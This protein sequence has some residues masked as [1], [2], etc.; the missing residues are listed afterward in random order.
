[1]KELNNAALL[2]IL[3]A[4]LL[5]WRRLPVKHPSQIPQRT[6][7]IATIEELCRR[8]EE[9]DSKF[10]GL[11]SQIQAQT[12]EVSRLKALVNNLEILN[13][14]LGSNLND[15]EV[16]L[17]K[18]RQQDESRAKVAQKV[19]VLWHQIEPLLIELRK[20]TVL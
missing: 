3:Q 6:Q 19:Q 4:P 20:D 2:Q 11:E 12:A 17:R 15:R 14:D 7:V 16:A 13:F 1:M 18:L 10:K 9:Y 5:E 8:I